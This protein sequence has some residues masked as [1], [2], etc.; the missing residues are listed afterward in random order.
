MWSNFDGVEILHF[1]RH[2]RLVLSG[3]RLMV[4]IFDVEECRDTAEEHRE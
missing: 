4:G 1:R 3:E 2:V